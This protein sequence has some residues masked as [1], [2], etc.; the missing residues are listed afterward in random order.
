MI[1]KIIMLFVSRMKFAEFNS[2]H[3][4]FILFA[5]SDLHENMSVVDDKIKLPA[6]NGAAVD[7]G[8]SHSL[9]QQKILSPSASLHSRPQ[10]FAQKLRSTS[11]SVKGTV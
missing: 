11:K 7:S 8:S 9:S 3:H 2:I 6:V 1:Y 4:G 5:A 10:S